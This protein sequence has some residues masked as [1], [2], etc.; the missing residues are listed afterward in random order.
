MTTNWIQE[1]HDGSPDLARETKYGVHGR[2]QPG[3]PTPAGHGAKPANDWGRAEP[4]GMTGPSVR[5]SRIVGTE[6]M[7]VALAVGAT[8]FYV[9]DPNNRIVAVACVLAALAFGHYLSVRRGLAWGP[10]R[11]KH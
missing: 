7:L 6:V 1:T 2:R 4:P 10:A 11:P 5:K 8:L 9:S 3:D